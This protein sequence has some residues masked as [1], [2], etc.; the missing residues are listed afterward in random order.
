MESLQYWQEKIQDTK[1]NTPFRKFLLDVAS[2]QPFMVYNNQKLFS[3]FS[4][5]R[6]QNIVSV[7]KWQEMRETFCETT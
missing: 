1:K 7:E 6:V 4:P 2:W 5:D 3:R